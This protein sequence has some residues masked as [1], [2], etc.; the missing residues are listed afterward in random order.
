MKVPFKSIKK[1][2]AA[3]SKAWTKIYQMEGLLT[4]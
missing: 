3:K 1:N 2:I 4:N